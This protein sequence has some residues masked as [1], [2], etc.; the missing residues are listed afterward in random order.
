MC[1]G[2]AKHDSEDDCSKRSY[3]G[4]PPQQHP[5]LVQQQ[6]SQRQQQQ[7]QQHQIHSAQLQRQLHW[8]VPVHLS[9][10]VPRTFQ[11]DVNGDQ[12]AKHI[13]EQTGA[14]VWVK[15][16]S[17]KSDGQSLVCEI[18]GDTR[19]SVNKANKLAQEL[20]DT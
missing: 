10:E 18:S 1:N 4:K 19:E 5:L 14:H 7:L 3:D 13:D 11:H 20:V 9:G 8:S 15:F 17:S 16:V 2:L 12:N 6:W